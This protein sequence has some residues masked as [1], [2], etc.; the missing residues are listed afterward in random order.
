MKLFTVHVYTKIELPMF[1]ICFFFFFGWSWEWKTSPIWNLSLQI[2][3]K[4]FLILIAQFLQWIE[5]KEH[6]KFWSSAQELALLQGGITQFLMQI[7]RCIK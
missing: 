6:F 2:C 1:F 7:K 5:M 4:Q 3:V